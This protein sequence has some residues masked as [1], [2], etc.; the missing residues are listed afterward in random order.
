PRR[1]RRRRGGRSSRV[2]GSRSECA[3]VGASAD[4]LLDGVND[5]RRAAGDADLAVDA[6]EVVF[7]RFRLTTSALAISGLLSPCVNRPRTSLSRSVKSTPLFGAA[8]LAR[9]ISARAAERAA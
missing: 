4:S 3:E 9:P 7:D 5:G 2:S 1:P 6:L 8:S